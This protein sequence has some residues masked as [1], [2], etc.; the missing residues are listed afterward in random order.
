MDTEIL[1]ERRGSKE[2]GN[3]DGIRNG[4]QFQCRPSLLQ[5]E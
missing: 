5:E 2:D 3:V 4:L 1:A